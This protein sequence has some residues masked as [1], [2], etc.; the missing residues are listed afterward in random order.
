[1]A[2]IPE[3]AVLKGQKTPKMLKSVF[4]DHK[5][6]VSLFFSDFYSS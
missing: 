5:V 2:D 6:A 4:L 3:L 1:M